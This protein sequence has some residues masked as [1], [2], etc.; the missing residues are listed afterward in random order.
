M[1]KQLQPID[2]IS[3]SL[4]FSFS[5]LIGLLIWGGKFCTGDCLLSHAPRIKDFNW[6]DRTISNKDT[7]FVLTFD[8]PMDR[9]SVEQNLQ[10]KPPLAGKVSWAGMR[11]AYTLSS[12]APYGEKYSISLN[13]AKAKFSDRDS[14]DTLI[15]P[16]TSQFK[17][18]DR[19]FAYIGSE[20]EEQGRLILY[21]LTRQQKTIL[22][23]AN[24][25]VVDF[26]A[27]QDGTRILF[28]ATDKKNGDDAL[29]FLR[30]Y[31]V[32]TKIDSDPS[33]SKK[34]SDRQPEIQ[35]VLD[36][37]DYQNNKF[38]LSN[39]GETIVVQRVNRK[40]PEDFGL[41]IIR[42]NS[43]PQPLNEPSGGDF[44]IT[45]DS[46]AIAVA[47]GEGIALYP[48][49]TEAKPL[50]FLPKFGRVLSFSQ[51]GSA[52]AMVNFNTDNPKLSYTRSLFYVNNQGIQKELLNIEGS[53]LDC[54]FNPNATH[55]YC[56]LT[57]LQTGK[58][59]QEKPYL[60][61]VEIATAKVLPILALPDRQDVRISM[62]PDGLGVLFDQTVVSNQASPND[63]MRNNSGETIIDGRLWLLIPPNMATS[64]VDRPELEQLPFKGF[65]P[66]WLP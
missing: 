21:N 62:A 9:K 45:P 51:D 17:T 24:L 43:Q 31:T 30:L 39:D 37:R 38:D 47:Q 12:P 8:R 50:D 5:M 4:L 22:T 13:G 33:K 18:R 6:H 7:A 15:K 65:N 34:T 19:A 66:E 46:Q 16:F 29:R 36:D 44:V 48:L 25:T 23:P 3:L 59:Y 20:K 35:L 54:Q 42:N 32:T 11:L 55:L 27:Y 63:V 57:Q 53:I 28:S 56:L 1:N 58:E 26:K 64:K 41:W 49:H 61:V 14:L 60:A 40:K 10:I 2:Q 52:A